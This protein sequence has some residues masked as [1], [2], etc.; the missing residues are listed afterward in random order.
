ML[1]FLESK[2][3]KRLSICGLFLKS[4][5]LIRVHL[6]GGGHEHGFELI[7]R[8]LSFRLVEGGAFHASLFT[9]VAITMLANLGEYTAES[10]LRR[11]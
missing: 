7:Q 11:G 5:K 2:R 10:L 6:G 4:L 1:L 8:F 3:R 9:H